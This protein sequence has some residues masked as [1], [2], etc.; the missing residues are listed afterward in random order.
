[1]GQFLKCLFVGFIHLKLSEVPLKS[2]IFCGTHNLMS[3]EDII[4]CFAMDFV[5]VNHPFYFVAARKYSAI[6]LPFLFDGLL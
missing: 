3:N 2:L 5:S 6:L 4:E 1:M